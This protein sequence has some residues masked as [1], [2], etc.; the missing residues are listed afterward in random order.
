[1]NDLTQKCTQEP[2]TIPQQQFEARYREYLSDFEKMKDLWRVIMALARWNRFHTETDTRIK[3]LHQSFDL[4][5]KAEFMYRS[6]NQHSDWDLTSPEHMAIYRV[7]A[8]WFFRDN[9]PLYKSERDKFLRTFESG[10]GKAWNCFIK[11]TDLYTAITARLAYEYLRD[12]YRP[13][14]IRTYCGDTCN[15]ES[16]LLQERISFE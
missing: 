8:P 10:F 3:D 2:L 12:E 14:Q 7:Q 4:Q 13:N 11:T 15:I 16:L 5:Q 1:M 9:R 6:Y